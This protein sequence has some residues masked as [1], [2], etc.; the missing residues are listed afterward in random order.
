[1]LVT[2]KYT[3][4]ERENRRLSA[5]VA[6]LHSQVH[7]QA[8]AQARMYAASTLAL[9]MEHSG[10]VGLY[11]G[12]FNGNDMEQ[13]RGSRAMQPQIVPLQVLTTDHPLHEEETSRPKKR[14]CVS[15]A[16]VSC[17]SRKSKCNGVR[18]GCAA[19]L[20]HEAECVYKLTPDQRRKES[21]SVE[22]LKL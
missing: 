14:R 20:I 4:L 5:Q 21:A 19:C 7:A 17:K 22:L 18:S 8:Q 12:S 9:Q 16:R 10:H 3:D 15:A 6:E 11:N 1:M 2:N 13:R